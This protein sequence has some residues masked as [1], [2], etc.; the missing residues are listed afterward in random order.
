M[1]TS[2]AVT[3]R[4][5]LQI[6]AGTAALPL[7]HIQT[8]G[9]AGRVSIGFVDHWVP[10]GNEVMRKQVAAWAAKN[11]VDVRPDFITTIGGKIQLTAAAE[12]QSRSGHDAFTFLAWDGHNYADRLAPVDDVMGRLIE[13]YGAVNKVAEYLG[14]SKGS[15]MVV[16]SSTSTQYK[17]PCGRISL[18]KQEAGIDVTAMYPAAPT[19]AAASD[20]WTYAAH[21]KA[22]AACNKAGHTFGIGLGQTPD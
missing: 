5:A 6:G 1:N 22:A 2:Q 3:R 4:Q 17:G 14:K 10:N 11:H 18:L 15:W 19:H 12:A 20:N 13:Q 21:L 8:A 9:A 16:P 7:V